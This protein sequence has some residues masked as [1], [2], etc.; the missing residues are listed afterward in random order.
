MAQNDL[1]VQKPKFNWK[2]LVVPFL[3]ISFQMNS[4]DLIEFAN[5]SIPLHEL[6]NKYFLRD[7]KL[8]NVLGYFSEISLLLIGNASC[9]LFLL[10][11]RRTKCF[12]PVSSN[13]FKVCN[14][15]FRT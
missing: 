14:L 13:Y 7:P 2:T 5:F 12:H 10:T 8:P 3:S 15:L 11:L 1:R 9:I 6:F 4:G